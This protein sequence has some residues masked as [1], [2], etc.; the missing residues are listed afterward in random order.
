VATVR[1]RSKG[2]ISRHGHLEV[3]ASFVGGTRIR[4]ISGQKRSRAI[5]DKNLDTT[6]YER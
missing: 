2:G 3:D 6:E 1:S 5:T 4:E